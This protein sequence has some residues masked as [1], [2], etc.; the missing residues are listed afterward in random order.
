L[1]HYADG[2]RRPILIGVVSAGKKCGATGLPSQYTR[3]A[4]VR[5]WI[6]NTI[7]PAR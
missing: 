1:V 3:V 5:S 4:K 7:K 6:E 2:G